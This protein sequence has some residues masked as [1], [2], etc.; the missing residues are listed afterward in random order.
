[1][2]AVLAAD[3]DDVDETGG[4][5]Q[6]GAGATALEQGVGGDGRAVHEFGISGRV[7]CGGGYNAETGQ[8]GQNR[9]A[10]VGGCSGLFVDVQ[11]AV[12]QQDEVGECAAYISSNQGRGHCAC[13]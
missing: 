7:T 11:A 9:L 12:L 6:G 13:S 8:P 5:E 10:L 2:G 3:L 1:M 4:G